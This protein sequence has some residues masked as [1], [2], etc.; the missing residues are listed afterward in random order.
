MENLFHALD[1]LKE[2]L[3]LHPARKKNLKKKTD[4]PLTPLV[5]FITFIPGQ[6]ILF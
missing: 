4:F 3:Q 6:Y 2:N 1:S 5:Y